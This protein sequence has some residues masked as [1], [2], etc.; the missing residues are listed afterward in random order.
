MKELTAQQKADIVEHLNGTSGV[1]DQSICEE[2]GLEMHELEELCEQEGL[3]RCEGECGWWVE[4]DDCDDELVCSECR[5]GDE[6]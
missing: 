3:V 5:D 6:E 4:R 2:H 1:Y